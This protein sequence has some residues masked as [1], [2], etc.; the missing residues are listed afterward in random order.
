MVIFA[1]GL[2]SGC[3]GSPYSDAVMDEWL[4]VCMEGPPYETYC[5]CYADA[6]APL[7][8]EEDFVSNMREP[9]PYLSTE[10]V[11]TAEREC[12][13]FEPVL[14]STGVAGVAFGAPTEKALAELEEIFGNATT[15][16]PSQCPGATVASWA[17]LRAI[18]TE[19]SFSGWAYGATEPGIGFESL[20]LHA[21]ITIED[22]TNFLYA[23]DSLE[24]IERYVGG[25][26]IIDEH[27]STTLLVTDTAG[28]EMRAVAVGDSAVRLEA[29]TRCDSAS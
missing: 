2:L 10:A 27:A 22:I 14:R 26:R 9:L 12:G 13:A 20:G 16:S 19:D 5:R 1:A 23:S 7:S 25:S 11:E 18:F 8:S 6:V 4:S 28:M 3:G 21:E 29:G 24:R 15:T 17:G